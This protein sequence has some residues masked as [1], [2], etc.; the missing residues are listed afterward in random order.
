MIDL[1]DLV[2]CFLEVGCVIIRASTWEVCIDDGGVVTTVLWF[3]PDHHYAMVTI[4]QGSNAMA[5]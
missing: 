4:R 1:L 2:E 3:K 5:N